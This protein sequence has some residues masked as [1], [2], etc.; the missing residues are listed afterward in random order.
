MSKQAMIDVTEFK[1]RVQAGE[2]PCL[3]VRLA[4]SGNPEAKADSR[5][6]S[7]VFSDDSIDRMGDTIDARGWQL[8][9]FVKNPIALFGHDSASV[10]N[11]VGRARNVRVAGNKLVG[12]IEFAE[13]AV[14]PNADV[15]FKMVKGGFLNAV[16][17]GFVP[18]EWKPTKN[19]GI[20]F[21]KQTLLEISVVPVPANSN[22]LVQARAAGIA[23]DRLSF[24]ALPGVKMAARV[25]E[26]RELAAKARALIARIPD[27]PAPKTRE[28]RLAEVAN[29]RR[30]AMA[31]GK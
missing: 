28:E 16:S 27:D 2:R 31:A 17:V 7:F 20:S 30:I 12:D 29:F 6:V 23:V 22:A 15:V 9:Q 11:V 1:K 19:G 4:S 24:F 3:A 25:R 26:A 10:E 21:T 8:D 14:N 5:V 13:A 18:L